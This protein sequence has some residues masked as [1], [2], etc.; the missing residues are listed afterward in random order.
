MLLALL[1][2]P[3]AATAEPIAA[4]HYRLTLPVEAATTVHDGQVRLLPTAGKLCR[5][6]VPIFGAYRIT[7]AE[8]A[9]LALEQE[10]VC[11]SPAD[12]PPATEGE[13][14][15]LRQQA[16]LASSYAYLAAKDSGR[17]ADAYAVVSD[18]LRERAPFP[19][20]TARA[21]EFTAVAGAPRGR[22]ITEVT[23]YDNPPDAPEPGRYVAADFSADF[24][25]LEF[26]CG[27]L[28]WRVEPDGSFRLVREEQNF[29]EKKK[30][31]IA[32]LDREPLRAQ[33]GCKD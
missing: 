5:D 2:A 16:A 22:R 13:P 33:M 6:R 30:N 7:V 10:L 15:P 17:Y 12:A 21:E 20:W 14:D 29:I 19:Q 23:W 26:A 25:G 18:R 27:Y 1:L 28:M 9:A 3:A 11:F 31:G 32:S 8:N 24:A 4:N